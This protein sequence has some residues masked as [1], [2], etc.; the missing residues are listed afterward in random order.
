[1]ILSGCQNNTLKLQQRKE[2]FVTTCKRLGIPLQA[3]KLESK[4]TCLTFLGKVVDAGAMQLR[5]PSEKLSKLRSLLDFVAGKKA[6]SKRELQ[7][8]VGLL[9]HATKVV[10]PGSSFMRGFHSILTQEGEHIRPNHFIRLNI[11]AKAAIMWR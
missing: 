6:M 11:A 8:L 2:T 10:K 3:S 5:L 1:M 9:Q 7:S 4:T